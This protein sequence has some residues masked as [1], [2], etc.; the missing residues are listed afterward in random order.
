MS[1]SSTL[2]ERFARVREELEIPSS[3]PD[4]V[5]EAA[6]RIT[7]RA[8]LSDAARNARVDY[9]LVPFITID[10]EGS[11]DLDQALYAQRHDG[12]WFVLYAIAD[13]GHFVDRGGPIESEAWRRGV[14]LY[15][16]DVRTPLYPP[17][18]G[19]DAASLLPEVER[20]CILFAFD[21]GPDGEDRL[22]SVQPSII[23]S[24]AALSYDAVSRHLG[25]EDAEPGSGEFAG[26]DGVETLTELRA[27]GRVRQK[28][29]I[30]RGGVSLPI[31]A[32]HVEQWAPALSGYELRL[33]HQNDVEGWNAQI[34]LMT[35]IAA[36]RLM[37]ARGGGLLRVLD[38]PHEDRVRAFRLAARAVGA[39]WPDEVPYGDFVRALDPSDPVHAALLVQAGGVMGGAR[40]V[41]FDG[42]VPP[43]CRHA[44]IASYYA[45]VTAP[46]RRLAD[47]Y[48]L[49]LLVQLAA[50]Q[51]VPGT[52]L[53]TFEEL[54]DVM[55]A[56]DRL[57]RR[58][59]SRIVDLTE[60]AAMS[61][62]IGE[63]FDATVVRVRPDRV[64]VQIASPPVRTDVS[65]PET[66]DG[67]R[68]GE[69]ED[70]GTSLRIGER[71]IGLGQTLTLKLERADLEAGRLHFTAL[72]T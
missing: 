24:R 45:H 50:E 68:T 43:G 16:P 12:G 20:P 7:P 62:R 65:V 21:V 39:S 1:N 57:D 5:L 15:G 44:A 54:V 29:E 47:R 52:T 8:H 40:Y 41:A 17:A 35:G 30:E 42:A 38:K 31:A 28:L 10:P 33:K 49:D 63:S 18:L 22:L 71:V 53:S 14:T 13:V 23:R 69:L 27:I 37:V 64:S 6:D 46:L 26:C 3:F 72:Q 67:G 2:E 59:E 48:V 70:D 25:A 51:P 56:A 11:R 34:S 55:A 61:A 36:A 32:Q 4:D 66:F 58:Y 60:A 9:T 19:A